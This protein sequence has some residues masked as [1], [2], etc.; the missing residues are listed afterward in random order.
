MQN[1]FR[2]HPDVYGAELEDEDAEAEVGVSAPVESPEQ[3]AAVADI[4]AASQPEEVIAEVKAV[5]A[6]KTET[7]ESL[8]PEAENKNQEVQKTEN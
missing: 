1:C 6:E 3:P 4:D 7:A 8:V 2:A 5:E